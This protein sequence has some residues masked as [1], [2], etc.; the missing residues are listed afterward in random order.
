MQSSDSSEVRKQKCAGDCERWPKAYSPP[1]DTH[2]SF[3]PSLVPF[4]SVLN[5]NPPAWERLP[6]KVHTGFD[7]A[8]LPAS[9]D[10]RKQWP[11]CPSIQEIRDQSDCG[12]CW[13]FATVE[14]ATDR[15]CIDTNGAKK[16][17]LSTEDM[18]GCC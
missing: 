15:M 18:V 2:S 8:A 13:A 3:Q 12:S 1:P 17:H 9:F 10:S 4:F 16:D 11:N 7:I 14:A 6:L 5:V